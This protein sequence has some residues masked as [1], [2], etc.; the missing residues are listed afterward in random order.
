MAWGEY[1]STEPETMKEG[2]DRHRCLWCNRII[3]V[4]EQFHWRMSN[5][6][7]RRSSVFTHWHYP[8][9]RVGGEG[10]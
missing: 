1:E 4:G 3:K 8:S 7:F 9:C 10:D 6:P 2:D 5:A